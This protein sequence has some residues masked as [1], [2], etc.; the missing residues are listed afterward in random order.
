LIEGKARGRIQIK[1]GIQRER[2]EKRALAFHHIEGMAIENTHQPGS[3]RGTWAERRKAT[4]G[5][6][7]S[8]L[9]DLLGQ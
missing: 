6:E 7:K 9:G 5:Q 8:A 4:P 2:M 1:T 3:K